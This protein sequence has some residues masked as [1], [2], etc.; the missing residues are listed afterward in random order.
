[1]SGAFDNIR[2]LWKEKVKFDKNGNS[3]SIL[4]DLQDTTLGSLLS[5]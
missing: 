4:Q 1:M 2:A 3:E 5:F